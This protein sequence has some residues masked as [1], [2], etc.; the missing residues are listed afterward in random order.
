MEERLLGFDVRELDQ[1]ALW[2]V[3]TRELFLLRVD[4][5]QP[6][7]VDTLIWPSVFDTG[8]GIGLPQT[9]RERLYLAG[10]PLPSWIGPNAGLWDDLDRMRQY[11]AASLSHPHP[12][13]VLAVSW[14]SDNSFADAAPAGPSL[15]PV[16]PPLRDVSWR[17][18]GF[19]VA[20]GSMLSGLSNCGYSPDEAAGLR[21]ASRS[22]LNGNHLFADVADALRFKHLADKRVPEHA[23]F[24]VYGLF[25]VE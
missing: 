24:F 14:I 22:S 21:P 20:D 5:T 18:L 6:L 11:L 1:S 13:V 7:S 12:H 16:T 8:Q 10:I 9:H 17:L 15:E 4:V 3:A 23:P 25:A 2:D 19:D